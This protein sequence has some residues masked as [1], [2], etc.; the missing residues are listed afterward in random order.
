[1][2]STNITT[3]A[4]QIITGSNNLRAIVF[5]NPSDEDIYVSPSSDVVATTPS[6]DTGF[7]VRAGGDLSL[8]AEDKGLFGI[9]QNWYAIHGGSGDK[10]LIH[11]TL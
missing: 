4:T 6:E 3:T 7:L 9:N 2:A 11:N 10:V 8:S 1:M 5:Q